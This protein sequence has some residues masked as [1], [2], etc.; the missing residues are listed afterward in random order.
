MTFG[1]FNERERKARHRS[2]ETS[3]TGPQTCAT[4]LLSGR[5]AGRTK[6]HKRCV[7]T[8]GPPLSPAAL[9]PNQWLHS[10]PPEPDDER[11]VDAI[12]HCGSRG[13]ISSFDNRR[14]SDEA[15]SASSLLEPQ[16][17]PHG[18]AGGF[19]TFGEWSG[20]DSPQICPAFHLTGSLGAIHVG[21]PDAT[22]PAMHTGRVRSPAGSFPGRERSPSQAR[23]I[24][25]VESL[26]M[27]VSTT[28]SASLLEDIFGSETR[29][30]R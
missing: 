24:D 11:V 30:L 1:C 2:I 22:A 23:S 26:S 13:S 9:E 16:R 7:H 21:I 28:P 10:H 17:S 8:N 15:L 25:S 20:F 29:I 19:Y 5:M 18:L 14:F 6:R 12:S 3:R 4:A 27:P